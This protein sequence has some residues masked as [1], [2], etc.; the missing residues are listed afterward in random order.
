MPKPFKIGDIV[1]V[2][3]VTRA[4]AL[5]FNNCEATIIDF[6]KMGQKLLTPEG[7]RWVAPCDMW[8]V[9]METGEFVA[10]TDNKLRHKA[11]P[12]ETMQWAVDKVKELCKPVNDMVP[13]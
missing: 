8:R 10:Y 5:K 4:D 11:P 13:A 1:I 12:Q 2:H 9:Q 7:G 3:S 6:I